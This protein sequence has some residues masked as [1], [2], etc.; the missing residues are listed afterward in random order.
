[1]L[2]RKQWV[3][4]L[5]QAVNT[6]SFSAADIDAAHR[7]RLAEYPD[8]EI[9]QKAASSLVG[10]PSSSR[11]EV[12][13]RYAKSLPAGDAVRG[14]AVF[15]KN[16]AACH[17][18][19]GVGSK[20]GPDV[21][22]VKDKTNDGLLREILDP[23]RAVDQRYAEYVA[24]TTD[25]RVKNGILAEET[26]NAITLRGQ[27]GEQISLLRSE[28]ET[29]TSSGKSLMPEGLESQITPQDMADLLKYLASP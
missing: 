25:G 10:V 21:A 9:R 19:H 2:S 4:A 28:L 20:V 17:E 3:R 16:C 5:L 29:L 24:I 11:A 8:D 1:L 27:Q 14:Q 26:S 12:V 6:N 7:A 23:N 22:A 18:F 13:D 15:T